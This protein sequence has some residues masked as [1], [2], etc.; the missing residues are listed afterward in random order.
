MGA[1]V[2]ATTLMLSLLAAS[3]WAQ[4]QYFQRGSFPGAPR[5]A[6]DRGPGSLAPFSFRADA[7]LEDRS[8]PADA[9]GVETE[10]YRTLCVRLCDGFYFPISFATSARFLARDA[11]Q[12]AL[13][14]GTEA[15]LFYYLKP[16]GSVDTMTDMAGRPY[17]ELPTAFKYRVTLVNGC[18]CRPQSH[19]VASDAAP[20]APARGAGEG[21]IGQATVTEHDLGGR[22]DFGAVVERGAARDQQGWPPTRRQ[23]YRP[24]RSPPPPLPGEDR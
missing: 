7:Y 23:N 8:Q 4:A 10:G 16:G 3:S 2:G 24:G 17:R 20:G 18:G 19:S 22:Q 14:C 13:S 5:S 6:G 11:E 9:S 1:R 12:C 21:G 15:R